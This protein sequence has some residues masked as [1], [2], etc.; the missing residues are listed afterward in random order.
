MATPSVEWKGEKKKKTAGGTLKKKKK[1][2][3]LVSKCKR[4]H[5]GLLMTFLFLE[6]LQCSFWKLRSGE[7]LGNACVMSLPYL[8]LWERIF[9]IMSYIIEIK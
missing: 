3:A 6:S 1:K 5:D 9:V 4:W 7:A 8:T 2:R